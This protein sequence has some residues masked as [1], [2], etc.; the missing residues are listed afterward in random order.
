MTSAAALALLFLAV[1]ALA[2]PVAIRSVCMPYE[3][4]R[5]TIETLQKELPE[6]L[7]K[8]ALPPPA[9]WNA[10]VERADADIRARLAQ[11]DED[12]L[13]NL[14]LLGT[15]FTSQPRTTAAQLDEIKRRTA[16]ATSAAGHLPA[17]VEARIDDFIAA[18]GKP[19]GD[20]R[21]AFARE[22]LAPRIGAPLDS[23]DGRTR[24]KANLLEAL[25]RV[26]HELE[27][28][29]QMIAQVKLLGDDT[30]VFVER[31]QIYRE[32]GLSSDT[33]L[34]P[35]YAIEQTLKE[36]LSKGLV[37]PN[38]VHRVAVVGPGLD[39]ADKQAGYDFYPQQ[40][41][42]P[43]AIADTLIRL[44]LTTPEQV[45]VT[46]LDLSPK[47]NDHVRRARQ[48]GLDGRRYTIQLPLA[49]DSAWTTGFLQYWKAFGD[50]IGSEAKPV[51]APANAPGLKLRAVDV[52][53][54]IAAKLTA[55]DTNV[56]LQRLELP[57]AE[58]FDLVIG[59]NIFVYYDNFQK[60]L[61]LANIAEML[62]PGGFLLSN[63][64]L[65]EIP[66]SK[67]NWTGY[68][69]VTY[70]TS[71]DLDGDFIVWYRRNP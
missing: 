71:A 14:A 59:T 10:W 16:A 33:S 38:S 55:Y 26:L 41:I 27:S 43:F 44:G 18:L 37:Q 19:G 15:T 52:Q 5:P 61:A 21:L 36:L 49:S 56:V 34:R 66:S 4:A 57:A 35:N 62:R 39:F 64:A 70:S 11:G 53:P 8:H 67:L 2:Q 32:R 45:Q 3:A 20:E 1:P 47:V 60:S 28:Y 58:K 69:K 46:T 23:A 50:R 29:E 63:Q 6:E 12:S 40:T 22:F 48:T 51:A 30:A 17:P 65:L 68:S 9:G 25:A 31:S 42:Q 13:V 7:A 24:A 54:A